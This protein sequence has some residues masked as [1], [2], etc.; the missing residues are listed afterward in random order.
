MTVW[1]VPATVV[2]VIDGD[3]VRLRLDLGWRIYFEANARVSGI[4]C[5]EMGTSAGHL[6]KSY[7]ELLLP[8]GGTVMFRSM[9]LDKYGRPLGE[10][11]DIDGKD[12]GAEMIAAGHA[13]ALK[14]D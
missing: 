7:A 9:S 11:T 8:V 12:F 13:V 14:D 5:A 4:N 6:A 1:N 2:R 3:T 10:I